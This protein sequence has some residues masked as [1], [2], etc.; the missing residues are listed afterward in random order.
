MGHMLRRLIGEDIQLATAL[1]PSLA[2]VRA[3]AGQLEQVIL[4]LAIN[5]RDAMPTG[6]RLSIETAN[7][8][9]DRFV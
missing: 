5:A 3:D 2:R 6:G 7:V 4:N 8:D 1:A 9:I